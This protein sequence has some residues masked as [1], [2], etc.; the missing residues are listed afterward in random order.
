MAGAEAASRAGKAA[1]VL[2][3]SVNPSLGFAYRLLQ[4]LPGWQEAALRSQP[5][6]AQRQ[7]GQ[8]RPGQ[9]R[10]LKLRQAHWVIQT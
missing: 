10:Q 5:E 7:A 9:K 1:T 3:P 6:P 4:S 2:V 8:L